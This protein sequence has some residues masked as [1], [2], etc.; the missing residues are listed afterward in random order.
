MKT[1]FEI[2]YQLQ[3]QLGLNPEVFCPSLIHYEGPKRLYLSIFLDKHSETIVRV[4]STT[5]VIDRV[6]E[7]SELVK[8]IKEMMRDE[9]I[10]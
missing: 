1:A 6:I 3:K 5:F 8:L 7:V 9:K 10:V 2:R 4:K